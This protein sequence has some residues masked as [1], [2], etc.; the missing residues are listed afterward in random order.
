VVSLVAAPRGSRPGGSCR[1]EGR[2]P[3]EG[4]ACGVCAE[5]GLGLS[6]ARSSGGVRTVVYQTASAC[7]SSRLGSSA[8]G[9]T[10]ARLWAPDAEAAAVES[11]GEVPGAPL[12]A[13]PAAV[14]A[15]CLRLGAPLPPGAAA[16]ASAHAPAT[17]PESL[18]SEECFFSAF[19]LVLGPRVMVSANPSA[20]PARAAWEMRVRAEGS[21]LR[22]GAATGAAVDTG[23]ELAARAVVVAAA[24]AVTGSEGNG[25]VAAGGASCGRSDAGEEG[26]AAEAVGGPGVEVRGLVTRAPCASA[27]GPAGGFP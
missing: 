15:V 14:E 7:S 5:A 20:G 16:P 1:G 22:A 13:G 23:T 21:S 10:K 8:A 25:V 4:D 9:A 6:R 17:P 2:S 27:E 18:E 3:A 11:R 12:D 24:A 19:A 26:G